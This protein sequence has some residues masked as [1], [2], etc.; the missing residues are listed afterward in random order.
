MFHIWHNILLFDTPIFMEIHGG[1]LHHH[2]AHDEQ[3]EQKGKKTSRAR[4]ESFFTFVVQSNSL[5]ITVLI[6]EEIHEG[7][8]DIAAKIQERASWTRF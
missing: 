8:E 1:P 6:T 7:G 4:I 5:S 2:I 3:G